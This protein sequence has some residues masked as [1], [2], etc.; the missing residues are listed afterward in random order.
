M[1]T[2]D[3]PVGSVKSHSSSRP[4]DDIIFSTGQVAVWVDFHPEIMRI[5][6]SVSIL[7][8]KTLT[9]HE[10]GRTNIY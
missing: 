2:R 8:M 3:L 9:P 5:G 6:W 4:R 1:L 10:W 7:D